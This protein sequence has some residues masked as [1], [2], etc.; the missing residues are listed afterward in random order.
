MI[1]RL[2]RLQAKKSK[3]LA[4]T[5]QDTFWSLLAK[6][7]KAHKEE[8][9]IPAFDEIIRKRDF[10]GALNLADFLSA[11]KYQ[12]AHEHYVMNQ[13]AYLLKKQTLPSGFKPEERAVSKFL[14]TEAAMAR[15]NARFEAWDFDV[16]Y[17]G[18]F[19][20]SVTRQRYN[21][22]FRKMRGFIANLLGEEPD[23][24]KIYSMVGF[25][26]GASLKV[27]GTATNAMRKLMCERGLTVTPRAF[28]HL[29][30]AISHNLWLRRKFS[31]DPDGHTDGTPDYWVKALMP[32]CE[33]VRYNKITFVPKTAKVLRTIAVEPLGNSM[34]QKGAGD[35]ISL[36]LKRIGIDL[37]SQTKNQEFARLGSLEDPTRQISTI[38]LSSASDS[39]AYAVV[40]KLFPGAWFELLN[41]LRSEYYVIDGQEMRRY[42]KFSSMGNGTTFPIETLIFTAACCAAGA[43]CPGKDFT[44]YGDDIAV[45]T[46][47]VPVLL[48]LLR[49]MGFRTNLDKTFI[50][51]PFR[52]SCGEDWFGGTSVRPF[53]LDYTFEKVSDVYKF[54]NQT[55]QRPHWEP[56]FKPARD[57][58]LR[59]LPSDLRFFRP[60]P[61]PV[62]SAIETEL[63]EFMTS[64]HARFSNEHGWSWVELTSSSVEDTYFFPGDH[65]LKEPPDYVKWYGVHTL[66][67]GR[68]ASDERSEKS[69][70]G[71]PVWFTLR[72]TVRTRVTREGGWGATS[73]WLPLP[74]DKTC[75]GETP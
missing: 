49:V 55:R 25:G 48:K 41:S 58:V 19:T 46:H 35:F 67:S 70:P 36:R 12:T 1:T 28:T 8:F 72:R 10:D 7:Y 43:G 69:H 37:S 61:G 14:A 5:H 56:F 20:A 75:R 31:T 34:L 51:G 73:N 45:P 42:A 33:F 47:C 62:D 13:F 21:K 39:V 15:V 74:G 44:V 57:F 2:Q 11:Q 17:A 29:A 32:E 4:S 6:L 66:T 30:S 50:Q 59:L 64:A 22:L 54:L 63:D 27:S 9:P 23:L 24:H 53:V 52:E 71:F 3:E 65:G 18:D 40:K 68:S 26:P 16:D 38:D 60:F